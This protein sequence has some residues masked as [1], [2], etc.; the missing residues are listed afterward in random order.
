MKSLVDEEG[1][2]KMDILLGCA[3]LLI[4][5]Y[6]RNARASTLPHSIGFGVIWDCVSSS[7]SSDL[8]LWVGCLLE[9]LEPIRVGGLGLWG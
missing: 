7:S 1:L 5:T 2:P 8:E 6:T 4:S 9:C 3:V